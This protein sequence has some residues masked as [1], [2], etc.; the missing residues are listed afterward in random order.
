MNILLL[1]GM[2]LSVGWHLNA[3]DIAVLKVKY[4]WEFLFR[5]RQRG[6][7]LVGADNAHTR[8]SREKSYCSN[9]ESRPCGK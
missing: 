6:G 7:G 8:Q 4:L 1:G 3:R 9:I 2:C 5:G